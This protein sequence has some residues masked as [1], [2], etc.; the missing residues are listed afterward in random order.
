MHIESKALAIAVSI[1]MLFTLFAEQAKSLPTPDWNDRVTR[2]ALGTE[3]SI[4]VEMEKLDQVKQAL[5]ARDVIRAISAL[6]YPRARTVDK[7]ADA[8]ICLVEHSSNDVSPFVEMMVL[9]SIPVDMKQDVLA[10]I[11]AK[12]KKNEVKHILPNASG[13]LEQTMANLQQA[14]T[15]N[16]TFGNS[17]SMQSDIGVL[18]VPRPTSTKDR[19]CHDANSYSILVEPGPYRLQNL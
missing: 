3:S 4:E 14:S 17:A 18:R 16:L 6:P 10:V 7:L 9:D 13:G 19:K 15:N 5:L 8:S 12:R 2:C 11:D 1:A